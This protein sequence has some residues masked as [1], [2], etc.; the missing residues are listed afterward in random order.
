MRAH[1]N[2][3]E[4]ALGVLCSP[5]GYEA[6]QEALLAKSSENAA[7]ESSVATLVA[8]GFG[9][10]AAATALKTANGDLQAAA[11]ALSDAAPA[12]EAM[13][14]DDEAASAGGSGGDAPAAAP[15]ATEEDHRAIESSGLH[16][17]LAASQA[18]YEAPALAVEGAA[19]EVY[20]AAVKERLGAA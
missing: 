6:L 15:Q 11:A 18:A 1:E 17:A 14:T 2:N 4:A 16:A 7:R 12:A 19:I 8:M 5:A 13:A 20:V 10:A 9:R 3:E